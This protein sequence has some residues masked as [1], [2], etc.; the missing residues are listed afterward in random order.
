MIKI[1]FYVDIAFFYRKAN[2]LSIL[3][4]YYG[5]K[6]LCHGRCRLIDWD[7]NMQQAAYAALQHCSS[8]T[9][10]YYLIFFCNS[11]IDDYSDTRTSHQLSWYSVLTRRLK[12]K[13][14]CCLESL[15]RRPPSATFR[16]EMPRDSESVCGY[17]FFLNFQ[18]KSPS[19]SDLDYLNS[20]TVTTQASLSFEAKLEN[21]ACLVEHLEGWDVLYNINFCYIAN[22]LLHNRNLFVYIA[23]NLTL[24]DSICYITYAT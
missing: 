23:F 21:T 17:F 1:I 11:G 4:I 3:P 10:S 20:N 2:I 9:E 19:D 24:Y 6:G 14:S 13:S 15:Q 12:F 7:G 22:I 16:V 8:M 5:N 18:V